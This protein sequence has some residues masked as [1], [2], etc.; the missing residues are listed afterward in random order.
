MV[1][2][3]ARFSLI[4]RCHVLLRQCLKKCTKLEVNASDK[5][6]FDPGKDLSYIVQE[7]AF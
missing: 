4:S 7:E 5:E 3:F 6:R 1:L 2:V